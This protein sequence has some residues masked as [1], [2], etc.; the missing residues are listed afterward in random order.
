M[1]S[2]TAN[3]YIEMANFAVSVY[4]LISLLVLFFRS[5]AF[6]A[7]L[8]AAV[9]KHIIRLKGYTYTPNED[10]LVATLMLPLLL[11][12]CIIFLDVVFLDFVVFTQVS[13]KKCISR[14]TTLPYTPDEH[15]ERQCVEPF[16]TFLSQRGLKNIISMYITR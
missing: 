8:T 3:E 6:G 4:L 15:W 11:T 16:W 7:F 14:V 5:F 12:L 9:I 2:Y 10:Y 13:I 1:S